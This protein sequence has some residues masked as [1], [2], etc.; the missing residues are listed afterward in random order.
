MF[1]NG[2]PFSEVYSVSSQEAKTDER[3]RNSGN[4]VGYDFFG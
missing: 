1:A 4:F 2:G 3:L